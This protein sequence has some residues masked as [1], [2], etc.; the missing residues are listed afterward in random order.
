MQCAWMHACMAPPWQQYFGRW[1][2]IVNFGVIVGRR[3]PIHLRVVRALS[4]AINLCSYTAAAVDAD[5]A[6]SERAC[7]VC[8]EV[9]PKERCSSLN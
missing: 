9:S 5:A 6:D 4:N 8:N 2:I 7:N 1:L 3:L